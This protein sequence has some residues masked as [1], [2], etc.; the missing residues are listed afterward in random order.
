MRVASYTAGVACIL[1]VAVVW[2]FATVL[3]QIIFQDLNFNEPLILAYVCNACYAVHFPL[4]A[5]R[6]CVLQVC[7]RDQS[8][9]S[10]DEGTSCPEAPS[11]S[12]YW[13]AVRIGVVIAPIWFFSQ[14]SY[15][16][17]VAKT[18]VTSS[19]VISTTSCVWTLLGAVIFL[20]E[21]LT[22]LKVL[23]IGFCMAGNAVQL[24]GG[25]TQSG[26]QEHLWGDI[27]CFV[28]AVLYAV[29]STLLAGLSGESTSVSLLFGT[30]GLSISLAGAPVVLGLD[31]EGLRR[32]TWPIFGL[33]V[34]NG[35]FDNVLS[36]YAWLKAVQW[37]SSTTATV[38]LSLTIPLSVVADIVRS[39]PL[40]GWDFLSAGLVLLG[41]VLVTVASRPGS[42][43]TSDC[44]PQGSGA[45]PEVPFKIVG[46][47]VIRRHNF[48]DALHK[49][50]GF[51]SHHH[52]H[53]HR[54][55]HT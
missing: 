34:F 30:I 38:G 8:E 24:L 47:T 15:S 11:V 19:T 40:T 10:A 18:S 5:I 21:P 1:F 25:D 22:L 17:G 46:T 39:K 49:N 13:R 20:G 41:F 52:H 31:L 27:L 44:T 55:P 36:Q 12:H 7:H 33:L 35:F 32:L 23:G 51:N 37:T 9:G 26:H 50:V 42:V 14:W 45:R 4:R 29:Y 53:P 6:R 3:K 2:T 43:S 28:A 54:H 48:D 16:M